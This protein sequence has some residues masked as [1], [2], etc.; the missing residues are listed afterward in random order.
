MTWKHVTGMFRLQTWERPLSHH[1]KLAMLTNDSLTNN[2]KRCLDGRVMMLSC[3]QQQGPKPHMRGCLAWGAYRI[4][5]T[6]PL[7]LVQFRLVLLV[8]A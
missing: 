4:T 1:V 8:A 5:L 2:Y 7:I 3:K 6:L